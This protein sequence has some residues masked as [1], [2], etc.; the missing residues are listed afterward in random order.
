MDTALS[1]SAQGRI[2][3]AGSGPHRGPRRARP[4]RGCVQRAFCRKLDEPPASEDDTGATSPMRIPGFRRGRALLLMLASAAPLAAQ[5]PQTTPQAKPQTRPPAVQEALPSAR[6]IVDRHVAAIGGR[7]AIMAHT[8]SH[9]TGTISIPS[10]GLSGPLEVFAARPDKS[11]LK[12]SLG[13]LGDLQEGF[14]G[15]IGWSIS[16]MTGPTLLQGKQLEQKRF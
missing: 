7:A 11:L 4:G 5:V 12:M 6:Q 1:Q 16:A 3:V 8:S 14:D 9:A 15:T 2:F 10:A 13:G